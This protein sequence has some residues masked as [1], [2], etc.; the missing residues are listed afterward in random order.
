MNCAPELNSRGKH[1]GK[2]SSISQ[3]ISVE[4]INVSQDLGIQKGVSPS[5][6]AE[7][8]EDS[9]SHRFEQSRVLRGTLPINCSIALK[10]ANADSFLRGIAFN[11][12]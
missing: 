12:M 1:F 8:S 9:M 7:Q 2:L 6:C 3:A 11:H 4:H 10:R 5:H